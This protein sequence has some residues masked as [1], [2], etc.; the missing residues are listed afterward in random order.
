MININSSKDIELIIFLL[1]RKL[2]NSSFECFICYE[3]VERY[4]TIC[5]PE[6]MSYSYCRNC[7]NHMVNDRKRCPFTNIE[8]EKKDICLDYRINKKIEENKKKQLEIDK[9]FN[10]KFIKNISIKIDI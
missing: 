7:I 8:L 6:C 10:N 3:N 5:K 4:Y 9:M 2:N 1:K